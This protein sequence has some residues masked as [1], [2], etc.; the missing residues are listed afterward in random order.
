MNHEI[1]G[2]LLK[3]HQQ[4]YLNEYP[5]LRNH[6]IKVGLFGDEG[7]VIKVM[8][9]SVKNQPKTEVNIEISNV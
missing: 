1:D 5:T 9:V 6:W 3:I 4:G 7:K 8:D 2:N